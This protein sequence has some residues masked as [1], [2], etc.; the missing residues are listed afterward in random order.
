MFGTYAVTI[1]L[2]L[3]TARGSLTPER[4]ET[5]F[6]LPRFL[7]PPLAVQRDVRPSAPKDW[8]DLG[9]R[10]D[11][12]KLSLRSEQALDLGKLRSKVVLI[13][14]EPTPVRPVRK[15]GWQA[16]NSLHSPVIGPL[17]VVSQLGA[18]SDSVEW[19]QYKLT[20]RTGVGWKMPAWL[21]GEIQ[22]RGG[23]ALTNF[24]N[25]REALVPQQ[26]R[27]YLELATRWTL[28]GALQLEFLTEAAARPTNSGSD[29]H[30]RDLRLALPLPAGQVHIGAKYWS[31]PSSDPAAWRERLRIYMGVQ[32]TR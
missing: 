3:L 15:P 13:D 27:S 32:F 31:M 29:V 10:S 8:Y 5:T 25:E 23:T 14:A 1:A 26:A 20:G 6:E 18:N 2:A 12:A 7:T 19:Q 4:A 16:E 30:K 11:G 17:F 9:F 22:L 24:D 21:G 28:P